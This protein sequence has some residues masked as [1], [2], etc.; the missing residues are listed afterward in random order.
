MAN[1]KHSEKTMT[2]ESFTTRIKVAAKKFI[3]TYFG[4]AFNMGYVVHLSDIPGAHDLPA[5]SVVTAE[6]EGFKASRMLNRHIR[7][8]KLG[9][10]LSSYGPYT[11]EYSL[12]TEWNETVNIMEW[13]QHPYLRATLTN[14]RFMEKPSWLLD[15]GFVKA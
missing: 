8:D 9:E 13:Y 12:V 3:F 2:N 15:A 11:I 1:S 14:V 7:S 10:M 4:H 5:P 6:D